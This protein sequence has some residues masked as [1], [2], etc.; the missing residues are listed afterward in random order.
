MTNEYRTKDL[1]TI[2]ERLDRTAIAYART[3]SAAE[4]H[5]GILESSIEKGDP[6]CIPDHRAE[7]VRREVAVDTLSLDLQRAAIAYVARLVRES[8]DPDTAAGQ[9][10]S[11]YLAGLEPESALLSPLDD[12]ALDLLWR[13]ELAERFT[14]P[15]SPSKLKGAELANMFADLAAMHLIT[16]TS[17]HRLTMRGRVALERLYPNRTKIAARVI[18]RIPKCDRE[19]A[20]RVVLERV[21]HDLIATNGKLPASDDGLALIAATMLRQPELAGVDSFSL[22]RAGGDAIRLRTL[23]V[24]FVR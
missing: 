15:S 17:P 7:L 5:R 6:R 19:A 24:E 13:I 23:G 12:D 1:T 2:V 21:I 3:E 22:T 9:S 4:A 10:L 11:G 16:D 20:L 8:G 18:S 14:S